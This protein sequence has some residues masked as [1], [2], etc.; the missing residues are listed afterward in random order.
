MPLL[1]AD[2]SSATPMPK[3]HAAVG[4]LL[5][6]DRQLGVAQP[7]GLCSR[8]DS[9]NSTTKLIKWPGR[10]HPFEVCG[11]LGQGKKDKE[12]DVRQGRHVPRKSG[13]C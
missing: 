1:A 4:S 6:P 2:S 12:G 10:A 9:R 7:I 3:A 13:L 8:A 5:A 11:M